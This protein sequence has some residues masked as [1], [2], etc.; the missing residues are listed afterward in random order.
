MRFAYGRVI[1]ARLGRGTRKRRAQGVKCLR[2][3]MTYWEELASKQTTEQLRRD[4][5]FDPI[6]GYRHVC[7]KELEAR[8]AMQRVKEEEEEE[9]GEE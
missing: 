4:M 6:P 1:D 7:A 8:E 5:I 2:G 3:E 9:K